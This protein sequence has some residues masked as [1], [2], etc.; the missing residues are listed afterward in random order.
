MSTLDPQ[1]IADVVARV[2]GKARE[3]QGLPPVTE[4]EQ[5]HVDITALAK[6]IRGRGY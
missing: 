6:E 3:E 1:S 4:A 5:A 2:I